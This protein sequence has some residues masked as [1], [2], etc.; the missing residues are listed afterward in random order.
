MSYPNFD[1]KHDQQS[2]IEPR[3]YL[4]YMKQRGLLPTKPPPEA[5]ILCFQRRLLTYVQ[6]HHVLEPCDGFL[7]D[8]GYL[9]ETGRRVAI[10]GNFGIGAPAASVALEELIAFGV[11]RFITIG[12]AGTIQPSIGIGDLVVCDKAIRDEG[13]SHHYLG[14]GKY[15]LPSPE[16]TA[17]LGAALTERGERFHVGTSWTVDAPYRET[18]AE[19]RRYQEE[20]VA[21]VEMEAAALFAVGRHRG[22]EIAAVFSISDSLAGLEWHPEFHSDKTTRGLETIVQAAM[23]ALTV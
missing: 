11:R 21:T 7:T 8:L 10:M 15:A 13:T 19:A 14:P 9:V 23:S 17:K 22:V 4:E 6:T 2:M 3:R 5:V 1:G 12:T 18:V 20:G 16:L